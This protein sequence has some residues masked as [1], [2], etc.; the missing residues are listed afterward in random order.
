MEM[1]VNEERETRPL[2][3][4]LNPVCRIILIS[5]NDTHKGM[6]Y[7]TESNANQ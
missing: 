1:N 2:D 5:T 4:S 6:L 7:M 3:L